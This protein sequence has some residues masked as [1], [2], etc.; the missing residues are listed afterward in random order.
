M[1][2][3]IGVNIGESNSEDNNDR[4]YSN[5]KNNPCKVQIYLY[6]PS[7]LSWTN[8]IHKHGSN[9]NKQKIHERNIYMQMQ[10]SWLYTSY[11]FHLFIY[12]TAVKT[13]CLFEYRAQHILC[14][15]STRNS[16]HTLRSN[17]LP[18]NHI[19]QITFLNNSAHQ[20]SHISFPG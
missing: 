8:M 6:C 10:H 14:L 3:H 12:R 13:H 20:Y 4:R 11:I 17:N 15:I 7:T 18:R 16:Q 19:L 9:K 1:R 2:Q 5:N